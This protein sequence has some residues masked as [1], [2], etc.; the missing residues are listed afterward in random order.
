MPPIEISIDWAGI[1]KAVVD[2]IVAGLQKL[3]SP[4]PM[5]FTAFLITSLQSI[6]GMNGGNNVLTHIPLEWTTQHGEVVSLWKALLVPQLSLM[7]I[8]LVVQ[9]YRVM[10][11]HDI[12]LLP[13]V[14]RT[15][16]LYMVGISMIWWGSL[17]FGMVNATSDYV[18]Q[19]PLWINEQSAPSDL[20]LGVLMIFALVF[21]ALAWLKGAVGVVFLAVLLIIGPTFFTLSALPLFS[22]LGKWW[23][24]EFT[25]WC[26]RPIMVALIL[27]IGLGI[28]VIHGGGFQFLFAVVAF[29]LAW[30]IDSR[31]R[32]FSVG[33]WGSIGQLNLLS[34]GAQ[35]AAAA[36]AG[37]VGSAATAVAGRAAAAATP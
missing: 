5:E 21:A 20:T 3:A 36:V 17:I 29:W 33:A 4:L 6:L 25:T 26:L 19:Q 34:R 1:G 27:R 13:A 8:V 35:M 15:G 18:S 24:E 16:F 23:V 22:G 28:G 9:G 7:T 11:S 31:I 12:D 10:V 14:F 37:P 32:R 30:T 2:A